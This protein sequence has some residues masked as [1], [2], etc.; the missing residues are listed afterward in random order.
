VPLPLDGGEVAEIVVSP[1]HPAHD[2]V[3]PWQ[4]PLALV[5]VA[6][7]RLDAAM[8]ARRVR[9]LYGLTHAEARVMACLALGQTVEEIALAHVVRESTVRSQLR[10]LFA[11]TGVGRQADL[12]RLALGGAPLIPHP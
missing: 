10:S 7:P 3:A 12:V 8:I 5:V 4:L 11:K 9:L 2:L 6:A 1:L